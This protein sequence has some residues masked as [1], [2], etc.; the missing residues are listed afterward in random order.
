M[1]PDDFQTIGAQYLVRPADVKETGTGSF[2]LGGAAG[3][4]WSAAAVAAAAAT[5]TAAVA[6]PCTIIP[7]GSPGVYEIPW[8]RSSISPGAHVAM[9]DTSDVSRTETQTLRIEGD[10]FQPAGGSDPP[11]GDGDGSGIIVIGKLRLDYFYN[12]P[13]RLTALKADPHLSGNV[14]MPSSQYTSAIDLHSLVSIEQSGSVSHLR[15]A[16]HRTQSIDS[17]VFMLVVT[18]ADAYPY[19]IPTTL[20][21]TTPAATT[22]TEV[23][24]AQTETTP[25]ETAAVT[26]APAN[27]TGSSGAD[28]QA[29]DAG[30]RGPTAGAG[31][32]MRRDVILGITMAC[33]AMCAGLAL[34]VVAISARGR[35][36]RARLWNQAL[37]SRDSRSSSSSLSGQ[38]AVFPVAD[39]GNEGRYPRRYTFRETLPPGAASAG[40]GPAAARSAREGAAGSVPVDYHTL[41]SPAKARSEWSLAQRERWPGV[42]GAVFED[43]RAVEYF[44]EYACSTVYRGLFSDY[45]ASY[46]NL[47]SAEG[48]AAE[49]ESRQ[50]VR[51]LRMR[52]QGA[53]AGAPPSRRTVLYGNFVYSPTHHVNVLAYFGYVENCG[54][55][56]VQNIGMGPLLTVLRAR[57]SEEMLTVPDLNA[58][59]LSYCHAMNHITKFGRLGNGGTMADHPSVE[60]MFLTTTPEY[61]NRLIMKISIIGSELFAPEEAWDDTVCDASCDVDGEAPAAWGGGGAEVAGAIDDGDAASS[62][63]GRVRSRTFDHGIPAAMFPAHVAARSESPDPSSSSPRKPGSDGGSPSPYRRTRTGSLVAEAVEGS[64]ATAAAAAAAAAAGER[65]KSGEELN[66][67]IPTPVSS[68]SSASGSSGR[69]ET[70]AR[71]ASAARIKRQTFLS[72]GAVPE[73]ERQWRSFAET[74]CSLYTYGRASELVVP[75]GD[76]S[77]PHR[78]H[79]SKYMDDIVWGIVKRCVSCPKTLTYG[80][81]AAQIEGSAEAMGFGEMDD[82][83]LIVNPKNYIRTHAA[84]THV[85]EAASGSRTK[86]RYELIRHCVVEQ[87][88]A[89]T[90]RHGEIFD[91]ETRSV[92]VGHGRGASAAPASRDGDTDTDVPQYCRRRGAVRER[93]RTSL[94]AANRSSDG[95]GDTLITEAT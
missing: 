22:A 85:Y 57:N 33:V 42:N 88:H 15:F 31:Q 89:M 49:A 19:V 50:R 53:H 63:H 46:V 23:E 54:M 17:G 61:N 39:G 34:C 73:F 81:L 37:R 74:I 70:G 58:I 28:G 26:D 67:S 40:I 43:K 66:T 29:A 75:V 84:N 8:S 92:T 76:G 91:Y 51:I 77:E 62:P 36:R 47:Y 18:E 90:R 55:F 30:P 10:C 6:L 78:L 12:G 7:N 86:H 38:G 83:V 87:R 60:H 41:D 45:E 94:P 56:A 32:D 72:A 21:P 64:S 24:Q 65:Y 35:R 5:A 44:N 69:G 48:D 68:R 20:P 95:S 80:D 16:V 3:M 11:F 14:I 2:A 4:R 82:D 59:L 71:T 13:H 9:I 93:M 27:A 79:R 52:I 25:A 1:T